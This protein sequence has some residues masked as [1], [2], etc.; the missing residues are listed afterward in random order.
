VSA[1]DLDVTSTRALAL[2]TAL[3]APTAAT[4]A[5]V[6]AAAT[7][8]VAVTSHTSCDVTMTLRLEGATEIEHRIEAF[9]GSTV[10]L[11][12]VS[13]GVAIGEPRTIGRTRSLTVRLDRPDYVLRYRAHQPADRRDR[14]PL[15]VP[16][17]PTSGQLGTVRLEVRL[18][19]GIQPA[20]AM[21]SFA[22]TGAAGTATVSHVPAF[23]RVS[24]AG[25]GESASWDLLAVMDALAVVVF[26]L[27]S[28]LW[29]WRRTRPSAA[30]FV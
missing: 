26:V 29:L 14:C 23:V 12:A 25:P 22:W 18:P 20:S 30:S 10:A 4:A 11:E 21:P 19:D 7:I 24:Y 6:L 8:Q 2:A 17:V 9:D 1:P 15:W 3:L 5:P 13:G 16:A 28:A 27:A